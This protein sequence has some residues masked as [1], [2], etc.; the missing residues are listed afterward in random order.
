MDEDQ[1]SH[2]A[3]YATLDPMK[4]LTEIEELQR[5]IRLSKNQ[6]ELDKTTVENSPVGEDS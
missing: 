1:L 6:A 2:R 5:Q 4:L 3:Q